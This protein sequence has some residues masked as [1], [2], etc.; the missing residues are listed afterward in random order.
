[1]EVGRERSTA[2]PA[3]VRLITTNPLLGELFKHFL[4]QRSAIELQVAD[5]SRLA[6]PSA[7]RLLDIGSLCPE[8]L[9]EGVERLP[10]QAPIALINAPP[11]LALT[12]VA[13]YP[14]IRGV[15]SPQTSRE[16]LL[17][18]LDVLLAGQ[19]W[20]SRPLMAYLVQRLR[21]L[22]RPSSDMLTLREREILCLV[23]RGLSNA[24]IG[25][26]LCLSPHTVKSH[27]HNLLRKTGSANRAEA[28]LRFH[29]GSPESP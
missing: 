13:R 17:R 1:M 20:L 2:L 25:R 11:E 27:M 9:A 19:D 6:E 22:Q 21:A 24:A 10:A 4:E 14:G 28:A 5:L 26:A 15:F 18:G 29:A 3:T 8:R 12:W 23:G 16:Q 7:L